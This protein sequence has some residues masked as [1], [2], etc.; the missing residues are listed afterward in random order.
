M[1]LSINSDTQTQCSLE[2]VCV[3]SPEQMLPSLS[4]TPQTGNR[5]SGLVERVCVFVCVSESTPR[6]KGEKNW[7]NK[8][9]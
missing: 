6:E 4:H 9:G 1:G 8:S 3:C 2:F 7:E 5:T